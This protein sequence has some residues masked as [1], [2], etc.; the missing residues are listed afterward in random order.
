MVPRGSL[1][2]CHVFFLTIQE[3]GH[4]VCQI[5]LVTL[6]FLEFVV[7]FIGHSKIT[8]QLQ[9]FLGSMQINRL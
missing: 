2:Q 4:M 5:P 3:Q 1:G 6:C 8:D 9:L 7:F